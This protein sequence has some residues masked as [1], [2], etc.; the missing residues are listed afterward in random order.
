MRT[1][2]ILLIS[3]LAGPHASANL[4]PGADFTGADPAAN[5]EEGWRWDPIREP[6]EVL[7]NQDGSV[8][9]RGHEGYLRS[10]SFPTRRDSAFSYQVSAEVRGKGRMR[11]EAVWWDADR[12]PASP[13]V[14]V[15]LPDRPL[16]RKPARVTATAHPGADAVYGQVRFVQQSD[17]DDGLLAIRNPTVEVVSRRFEP[18][19]LLLLLDAA[20]PGDS[21]AQNWQDLAGLNRPFRVMGAPVHDPEKGVYG[22]DSRDE[23]FEGAVED[24]SRFDF[25][26]AKATG[27]NDPFT[28]VVY[29]SLDGPSH[30]AFIN[31]LE[32]RKSDAQTGAMLDAPGWLLSLLWD[33]F[34]AQRVEFHQM[35]NNQHDRIISRHGGKDGQSLALQPGE[36]HLFV[37]HVPGDG[38]A[39]NIQAFVDGRRMPERN[40]P[41]AGGGLPK[42]SITNDVPLRIGGGLPFLAKGHPLF[43]GSIGFIEI[44]RG[45]GLLEGMTPEQYGES[46]WNHGRPVR[47][48]I[49]K[50]R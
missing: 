30:G 49:A 40:V 21:P 22:I 28:I 36:M 44:W 12:Q 34:N 8:T 31:K 27:R 18:G 13:H 50:H 1:I 19:E 39:G 2:S 35:L 11:I 16:S 10:P 6:S 15:V 5:V 9:L 7:V 47:G 29:A 45:R 3:L 25:D 26:T 4:L 46:R 42:R 38:I 20:E 32:V 23:Y 37:V 33:E 14:E 41:W 48:L 43:T 17:T 24:E